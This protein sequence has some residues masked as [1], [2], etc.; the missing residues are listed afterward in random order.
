MALDVYFRTDIAHILASA[1]YG[2]GQTAL[3]VQEAIKAAQEHGVGVDVMVM[4][5]LRV[6]RQ[7]YRDAL[8][9]IALAFGIVSI[10]RRV[11]NENRT[12]GFG[13]FPNGE[14][15]AQEDGPSL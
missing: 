3:V 1:D 6:Y 15:A 12:N 5:N 14:L 7:G 2:S 9:T 13:Y 11:T 4:N 8:V 10:E